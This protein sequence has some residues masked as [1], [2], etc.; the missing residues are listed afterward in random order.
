MTTPKRR[1]FGGIAAAFAASLAGQTANATADHWHPGGPL[2]IKADVLFDG[3]QF[4]YGQAVLV[5]QGKIVKVAPAGEIKA[6]GAKVVTVKG[7]TILPG[8]I[9]MHTHHLVQHVPPQRI[10]EHGVTT[11]RDL[12]GP[13]TPATIDK[14]YQLRQ[15]LS[16]HIISAPGGYPNVVFPGSGVEIAGETNVRA[17]VDELAAG[18]ASIIALSLET[19]ESEGAAWQWHM[20]ATPPP[21][22][23]LTKGELEAIVDQAHNVH[24]L[25]VVAYFG[26]D[27]SAQRALD[28]GVDE[29]AHMPCDA[30]SPGVIASAGAKGVAIDTTIDTAVQCTGV[31]ENA[32]ALFASGA[33]I[34]YA[35]DMGHPDIPHGI[36]AQE[37]HVGIHAGMHN[38][39]PFPDAVARALASATSLAGDYLGLAPLGRIVPG[40][41]ADLI[42]IGSDPRANF[43]ELEFP[44]VVIKDGRIVIQRKAG[45]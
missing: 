28:A 44:R 33:K 43:K 45:Q 25:R 17:K 23:T 20:P 5:R 19:G 12:G 32:A 4:L 14:P 26:S 35:T 24:H 2:L 31:H 39:L 10:L 41:P 27:A 40:A 18:G 13:L 7:G 15:P 8:F 11:A 22:P 16:G 1:F 29:W 30:L 36:D 34:F 3:T 21:W 38:G 37:I 9:D 6:D 42:V